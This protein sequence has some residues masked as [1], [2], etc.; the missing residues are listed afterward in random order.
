VT[1][2][3]TVATAAAAAGISFASAQLVTIRFDRPYL[4]LV[5]AKTTGEALFLAAVA[6]PAAS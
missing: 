4:L 5:A 1:E 6:N 2:K 3:G